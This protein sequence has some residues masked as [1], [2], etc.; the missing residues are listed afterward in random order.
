MTEHL[1]TL[2]TWAS[3]LSTAKEIH[4][5]LATANY[6]AYLW[7]YLKRFYGPIDENGQITR[8]GYVMAQFSKYVRPGY[9]RIDASNPTAN[10]YVSAYKGNGKVVII[11]VNMNSSSQRVKFSI[12]GGAVP[13]SF[14]PHITSNSKNLS[15]EAVVNVSGNSFTCDLP[16]SG[17]ITFVSN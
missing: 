10:V 8:R 6:S 9:Q 11:A 7:W 3:V 15:T 1:D 5:C 17:V 14:T 2:T 13:G 4:D 16:A 12:S